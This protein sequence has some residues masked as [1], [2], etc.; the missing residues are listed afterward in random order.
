MDWILLVDD[1]PYDIEL[2][3]ATLTL[4]GKMRTRLKIAPDGRAAIRIAEQEEPTRPVLI[5]LDLGLPDYDGMAL[6]ARWRNNR[7]FDDVPILIL[8]NSDDPQDYGR[9][10]GIGANAYIP[11]PVQP[12]RLF[13][14]IMQVEELAWTVTTNRLTT[15]TQTAAATG[16]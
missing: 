14:V 11:K 12:E 9:A 7:A 1:N 16:T 4:K 5:F 13:R 6:L 15:G 8:T 2:V 10:L 3:I